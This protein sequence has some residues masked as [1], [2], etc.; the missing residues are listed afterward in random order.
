[1]PAA[2]GPDTFFLK[3]DEVEFHPFKPIKNEIQLLSLELKGAV[4][5]P[6]AKEGGKIASGKVQYEPANVKMQM[7][8]DL[9]AV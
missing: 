3:I 8:P 7:I 9:N 4:L 2:T 6:P 1:M 5:V